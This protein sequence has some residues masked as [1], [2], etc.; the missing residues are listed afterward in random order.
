M[1]TLQILTLALG[2]AWASGINLYATI[3]LVGGLGLFGVVDLPPGLEILE[4]PLVLI[5]AAVL[6]GIEFFADK[7]PVVDTMWDTI[8]TFIRIPAGA[9][10]AAGAIE[11]F[12]LTGMGEDVEF[13]LALLAGGALTAGTHATKTASRAAVNLS[14]EPFSNIA[15]SLVEDI[16]VFTGLSLALFKPVAFLV[17]AGIGLA[18]LIWLV[19]KLWRGMAAFFR[20]FSHPG[21]AARSAR[22]HQW[23][24][25][26]PASAAPPV[27]ARGSGGADRDGRTDVDA[28][29]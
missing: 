3:L 10:L 11:G 4:S 9:L 23:A 18:I 26:G 25:G 15:A 6:Y 8:H 7:I 24:P 13:I 5:A 28:S 14:P 1:D 22:A 2:A 27:I 12:D 21:E 29:F 19:P 20:R 16:L 17:A